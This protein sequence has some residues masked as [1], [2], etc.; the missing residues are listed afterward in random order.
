MLNAEPAP[1]LAEAIEAPAPVSV[2][3]T[4][5]PRAKGVV[6]SGKGAKPAKR[7]RRSEDGGLKEL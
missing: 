1:A 5:A 2:K 4:R 7:A 6:D 3:P